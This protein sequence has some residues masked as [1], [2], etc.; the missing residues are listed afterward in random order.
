MVR[1][2]TLEKRLRQLRRAPILNLMH[3]TARTALL[4]IALSCI[5]LLVQASPQG[6]ISPDPTAAVL[7]LRS[8]N[9]CATGFLLNDG[10]VVTNAHVA[11]SICPFG[12]CQ[13][14]S[15]LRADAVGGQP[16]PV[17]VGAVTVL[18]S[19]PALDLAILQLATPP[20]FPSPFTL[21]A[22][23]AALGAT[24]T[25]L[26]FPNCSALERSVGQ[27]ID[28]DPLGFRTTTPVSHGSSGSPVVDDRYQVIGI[29][30]EV[31]GVLPAIGSF[32][33]GSRADA[34]AV[35]AELL[36]AVR[37]AQTPLA[38]LAL[39]ARWINGF[40]SSVWPLSAP[41]RLVR[42]FHLFGALEGLGTS[43]TRAEPSAA[44]LLFSG[45]Q[46]FESWSGL[47][48]VNWAAPEIQTLDQTALVRLCEEH[49]LRSS[50][51]SSI[52][53]EE[54]RHS[55]QQ[56][57]R[58]PEHVDTLIALA[59]DCSRRGYAGAALTG[60][61]FAAGSLAIVLLLVLV[62]LAQDDRHSF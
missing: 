12:D 16:A 15:V 60:L 38:A 5:P 25:T 44:R 26:G 35:R 34:R 1:R 51:S 18:A 30:S 4:S 40:A 9:A 17:D 46:S 54:L 27:V 59:T 20:H 45:T 53:L 13:Q 39:Q 61:S 3:H 6:S 21:Q 49:G 14:L 8:Q 42:S 43:A 47:A 57:G 29:V 56:S 2:D 37:G 32:V 11:R 62:G 19:Y 50:P 33:L 10:R 52:S 7:Q 58:P 28:S 41:S 36:D 55:L 31:T 48:D 24:G 23:P 22:P